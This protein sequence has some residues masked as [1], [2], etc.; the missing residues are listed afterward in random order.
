MPKKLLHLLAITMCLSVILSCFCGCYKSGP[1]FY[2][3]RANWI[4]EGDDITFTIT[5][6]GDRFTYSCGEIII[7]EKNDKRDCRRIR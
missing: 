7:G 5:T 2:N 3:F 4:Y 6:H 1:K